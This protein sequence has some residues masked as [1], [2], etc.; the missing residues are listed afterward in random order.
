MRLVPI[1]AGVDAFVHFG[2]Q[3]ITKSR[4]QAA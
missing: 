3:M 4:S 2:I 1:V